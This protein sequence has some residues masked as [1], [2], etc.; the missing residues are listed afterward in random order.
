MLI[1]PKAVKA[2][3]ARM[4][5]DR[6]P[7]DALFAEIAVLVFPRQSA[8]FGGGLSNA[9]WDRWRTPESVMHSPY[10]A[11]ALEDGVSAFE[12]FVMPRGQ[13]WQGLELAD[14]G[15]MKRVPVLQW[16]EQVERRLFALR[17][18]PMSGFANA[19]HESAMSLF[20]FA[21][22]SMWIETRFDP[23][24][25]DYAGLSYQSEF[26][27]DIWIERD[28]EG[29]AMRIHRRCTLSN[30]AALR[31]FGERAPAK[32]REAVEKDRGGERFTYLHVIERNPALDPGRIDA[33]GKPWVSGYYSDDPAEMFMEGGYATLPR[34]YS[35]WA[36]APHATYGHSPT[37]TALPEIRMEQEIRLDRAFG[38]ELR[39]KPPLLAGDDE[40]DEGMLEIK[41]HGVTIGGLDERGE[42][43][44]KTFLE[45]ADAT[46]ARE[47][48]SE[49]RAVIDK[50]Y[51]RDL[52]QLNREYK[53]HIPANRIAEEVAEKGL[54]LGPLARQEDEWLS[55]MTQREL[56]LMDEMG[57]LDDMPE[58]VAAYFSAAGGI[59]LR[60]DNGLSH[61][62]EAGKSAAYL[63][64]AQQVGLLAQFDPGVVEDFKREYPMPKVLPELGRIAG[65]PA[66]MMATD[67]E[68][69]AYD[70]AKAQQ[71]QIATLIQAAPALSSA[72]KD[73]AGIGAGNAG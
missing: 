30:E 62:Q 27:G 52:L 14:E 57:L 43:K 21:V 12:G 1:D 46:D 31:K 64:L 24:T 51:Y 33:K 39:L 47:L 56:A 61:M 25:G 38:A 23:R 65:V 16:L 66:S 6:A 53:S 29:Y 35:A 45:D 73:I 55:R 10:A 37:M 72:A 20:S 36:R 2:N 41:A 15:L 22:Q 44:F 9:D 34:V 69:A 32:V 58:E 70:Q 71:Q 40:L 5:T 48:T 26:V 68:K 4:E 28:A 11:L 63:N 8:Y 3:Q 50:A 49:C 17:N 54:L 19:V 18:D 42:A 59:M 7:F 13:R 60:Y 67:E